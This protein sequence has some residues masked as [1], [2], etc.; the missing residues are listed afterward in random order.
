MKSLSRIRE[1]QGIAFD[2]V[3]DMNPF[4]RYSTSK[5]AELNLSFRDKEGEREE[6]GSGETLRG[7]EELGRDCGRI[8]RLVQLQTP[9]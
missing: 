6:N 4:I 9:G 5:R 7:R 3:H 2:D 8:Q 1:I